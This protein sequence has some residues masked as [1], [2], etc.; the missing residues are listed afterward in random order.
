VLAARSAGV[1]PGVVP[2]PPPLQLDANGR[3]VDA[4]AAVLDH[5]LGILAANEDGVRRQLDPEVL[6][7]FRIAIRRT[8]SV[9]RLARDRLPDDV[10]RVWNS[11]WE[12]LATV[13]SSPRDLDVLLEEINAAR[14]TLGVEA[15]AGLDELS[16]L[17]VA[18]R[19]A[20]QVSLEQGLAGDRY[21]TLKRGWRAGLADLANHSDDANGR[22]VAADLVARAS[23]QLARHAEQIRPESP[24]EAIH[25]VRK[26]T[27]RLRYA[28]ELFGPMLSKQSVKASLRAT[29]R[30][31][32]DLG[33][34]Q[35]NEV[36]R[37]VV[38][39]LLDGS[40]DLSPDAVA[41]GRQM[42]ERLEAQSAVARTAIP[43][44]LRRFLT[45]T[46]GVRH[47]QRP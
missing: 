6:H 35:D 10:A 47:R 22:E 23:K 42:I 31:Q 11:E 7:D 28:L 12:W 38:A 37:H 3:C 17:V 14:T 27:K 40:L 44:Q 1:E 24:A 43:D 39:E 19:A 26:R 20:A 41:A 2:G 34:F 5:Q 32:D 46:S 4:L 8:R 18:R 30:L 21:G 13:T 15:K 29:K 16:D 25:D 36:H 33:A 45:D 9:I